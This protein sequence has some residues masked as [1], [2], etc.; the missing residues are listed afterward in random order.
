M[1]TIDPTVAKV[2]DKDRPKDDS[3]D[4]DTL[5]EELESDTAALDAFR[6]K[7]IQQLHDEY[8]T[9]LLSLSLTMLTMLT[10]NVQ[11]PPRSRNAIPL[12][13]RLHPSHGRAPSI[14]TH[15]HI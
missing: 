11:T 12:P 10:T 1:T 15:N 7:R 13:R 14:N 3:E 5:L 2:L 9:V 6:E 4:E 8:D